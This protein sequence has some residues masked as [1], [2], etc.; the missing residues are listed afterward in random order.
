MV[1]DGSRTEPKSPKKLGMCFLYSCT[2]KQATKVYKSIK[3]YNF[4]VPNLR[5]AEASYIVICKSLFR[6]IQ[7]I[8]VFFAPDH[9]WQLVPGT[10]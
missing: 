6:I 2:E 5:E 9:G 8:P 1:H 10:I 4:S 7:R 3:T